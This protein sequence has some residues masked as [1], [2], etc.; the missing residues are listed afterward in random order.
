MHTADCIIILFR[1]I[2]VGRRYLAATIEK[3]GPIGLKD[4][5]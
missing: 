4:D 5:C 2:G 3:L 1:M